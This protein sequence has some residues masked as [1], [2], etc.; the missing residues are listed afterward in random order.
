MRLPVCLA[1]LCLLL[2]SVSAGSA[3]ATQ[4]DVC[5]LGSGASGM[6]AAAFLK[7]IG[8]TVLV[9]ENTNNVGGYCNTE[10][11]PLPPG[12]PPGSPNWIDIGVGIFPN[13]TAANASGFG[14]WSLDTVA[15]AT[16]FGSGY[17]DGFVIPFLTTDFGGEP[18][19]VN[20]LT[21]QDLGPRPAPTPEYDAAFAQFF[22]TVAQY[23]FLNEG[24]WPDPLPA[25]LLVSFDQWVANN[26]FSILNQGLFL[27]LG[28]I[29]GTVDTST[30]L[31]MYVLADMAPSVISFLFENYTVFEMYNGCDTIYQGI[32]NYIGSNNV[33]VNATTL[34]AIRIEGNVP[35]TLIVKVNNTQ[36]VVECGDLIVAYPQL[37]ADIAYLILDPQE[38]AIFQN[39]KSY[40]YYGASFDFSGPYAEEGA[41]FDLNNYN[42]NN[43]NGY[44]TFPAITSLSRDFPY[45][46]GGLFA[47]AAVPIT[48][49]A[50][51][52][53]I[54]T[55]LRG[56]P[57]DLITNATLDQ[58]ANHEKFLPHFSYADVSSSPNVYTRLKTL[59]GHRNTYWIGALRNFANSAALWDMSYKFVQQYF[60]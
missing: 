8:K 44:P 20:L 7:D 56:L 9:L 42:P 37:L 49:A 14:S 6:S 10:Y 18:E 11:F 43:A 57:V 15:F 47:S 12:V 52:A 22:E 27:D 55:Q 33:W 59:Q 31:A 45:G 41:T 51:E 32:R 36:K 39:V 34:T 53:V 54:S 3:G 2:A 50:M 21:G 5:I 26:N 13:S 4:R 35:V 28:I 23:P 38:I 30:T 29:G 16:R 46:P 25:E 60:V 48:G 19:R 58:F 40:Y 24:D 17:S 1:V